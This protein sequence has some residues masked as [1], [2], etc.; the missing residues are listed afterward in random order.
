MAPCRAVAAVKRAK[1]VEAVAAGAT[2][3]QAA[4]QVGYASRSGV[5]RPG[6]SGDPVWCLTRSGQDGLLQG[7]ESV[8]PAAV[9]MRRWP[10]ACDCTR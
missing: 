4:E 10:S 2:Y 1:V 6:V 7:R 9:P 3:E 5:N 8:R